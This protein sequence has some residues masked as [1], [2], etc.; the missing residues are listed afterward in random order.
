MGLSKKAAV[1]HERMF[2]GYVSLI[3]YPRTLNALRI[4]REEAEKAND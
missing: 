2:P 4:I 3:G 1:Y